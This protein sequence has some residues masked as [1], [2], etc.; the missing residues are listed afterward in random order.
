MI[1]DPI[2]AEV[3]KIRQQIFAECD[4]DLAKLA[5]RYRLLAERRQCAKQQS[6][7]KTQQLQDKSSNKQE[8]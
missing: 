4:N 3:H 5:E 1:N 8:A 7:L 6:V 2:V